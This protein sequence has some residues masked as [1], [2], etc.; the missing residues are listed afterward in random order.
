M[1]KKEKVKK[2]M[3]KYGNTQTVLMR[4]WNGATAL[5]NS[6]AVSWKRTIP[7]LVIYLRDMK[8]CPHKNLYTNVHKS[9][10]CNIKK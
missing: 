4:K 8:I 3:Q 1:Q 6:L 10:M 2:K 9:S 5:E 7:C